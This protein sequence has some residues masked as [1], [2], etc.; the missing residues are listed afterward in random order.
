MQ[1]N[2]HNIRTP[3]FFNSKIQNERIRN[4]YTNEPREGAESNLTFN[5]AYSKAKW[6]ILAGR[7]SLA[8]SAALTTVAVTFSALSVSPLATSIG[9]PVAI[10]LS[11]VAAVSSIGATVLGAQINRVATHK[12]Q[13]LLAPFHKDFVINDGIEPSISDIFSVTKK[14]Y[15]SFF[16][17]KKENDRVRGEFKDLEFE[18]EFKAKL[19]VLAG[20]IS[21]AAGAAL[22]VTSFIFAALAIGS[23]GSVIGAPAAVPMGIISAVAGAG[24]LVLAVKVNRYCMEQADNLLL[25]RRT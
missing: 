18:R 22:T 17:G 12:A 14:T 6:Y 23:L 7:A 25:M 8:A 2:L 21:L 20:R 24:A 5:Q 4:D 10:T 15:F 19:W 13:T 16:N 3:S 1:I 11:L 9:S